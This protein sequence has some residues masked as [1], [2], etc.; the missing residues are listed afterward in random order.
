M[1]SY[2]LKSKCKGNGKCVD[3]CPNDLMFLVKDTN[4]SF[5]Q[6]PDMCW[7]CLSCVK[8]CPEHAISIRPYADVAPLLSEFDVVRDEETNNISWKIKYRNQK[9]E[10]NFEF[11][12]RT[13]PWGSIN[14]PESPDYSLKE[15]KA[16]TLSGEDA[17]KSG[18]IFDMQEE[19]E[20][21][22]SKK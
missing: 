5:N 13:T 6:E 3:I 7:E 2:V 11:P 18:K 22:G 21:A 15:L 10:K 4:L 9:T 17:E 16:E 8:I 20:I 1:P 19:N 12:I 14:I